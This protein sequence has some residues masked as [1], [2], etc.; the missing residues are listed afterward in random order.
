MSGAYEIVYTETDFWDGPRKGIANFSGE[1]HLYESQFD[2]SEENNWRDTFLLMPIDPE[3][4]E[5]AVE[6]WQI[7]RRWETA[8]YSGQTPKE[9]HPALP[10]DRA[11]YEEI[12]PLLERQLKVDSARAVRATAEFR[13]REDPTWN[14]KGWAPLEVRWTVVPGT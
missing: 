3:T 13:R 12:A 14:G 6:E 1:P 9:T 7:W 8:F 4:F 2:E 11:R 5:F 10:E